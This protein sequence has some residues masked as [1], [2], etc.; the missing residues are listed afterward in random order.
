MEDVGR[1]IKLREMEEMG[2]FIRWKSGME[3]S[4]FSIC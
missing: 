1:N 3:W 4:V 2:L